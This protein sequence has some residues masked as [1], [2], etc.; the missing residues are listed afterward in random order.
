MSR[1][2][3]QGRAQIYRKIINGGLT[4]MNNAPTFETIDDIIEYYRKQNGGDD[5]N[6]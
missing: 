3:T 5:T 1:D 6:E 2:F 4:Q